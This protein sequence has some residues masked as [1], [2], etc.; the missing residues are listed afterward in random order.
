M[1][2]LVSIPLRR[3]VFHKLQRLA[4]LTGDVSSA[5]E[6]LILHWENSA[7][8]AREPTSIVSSEAQFW[9]SPTGDVLRVGETLKAWDAGKTHEA[10]VER[11]GIKYDSTIYD[12]PSAAARAVKRARG[13]EGVSTNTNG[14]DFWKV[15][16]PK[17]N[18]WVPISSLRPKY[19]IDT[20][21][22]LDELG[23]YR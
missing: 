13:L 12:S 9:Q 1:S 16:D 22:A 5:I 17:S 11:E 21:R 2:D 6:R 10:T 20:D 23:A 19:R 14:R 15:R 3:P 8:T 4:V 18:R 7:P